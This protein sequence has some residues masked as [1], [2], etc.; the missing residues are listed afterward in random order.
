M[1]RLLLIATIAVSG[2]AAHAAEPPA[3]MPMP[4][5]MEAGAGALAI[6]QTF[7]VTAGL[8][9]A[10]LESALNRLVARLSRQTGMAIARGKPAASRRATLRV[11]CAARGPAYPTLGEDESYQ[12]EVTPEGAVLK[13]ATVDGAMH[14]LE[15]FAQL[16]EPGASGFQAPA[17]RI[18]DRPRFPWR[19][20]M[21]DVSRHWMPVEVVKRNLDAMA[22][23]KLN[24]FHWH[25]SDDQG[26]RVESKRY[27][28]LQQFGSG[29]HYYT[30]A[31]IR[32][33][34]AYARERGIRVVPEFDMPG[35][36]VSWFPGYPQLASGPGPY[37][38]GGDFGTFDPVMDPSREETYRFL[39]GFIGEMAALFP[40][41]FF[42]VGGDEVNGRQWS[43]SARVQAFARQHRFKDTRHI[44]LYFSQR[45]RR[46]LARHGKTMVGW[47]EILQPGLG[48][49]TVIDTW[50]GRASLAESVQQGYRG[51]LSW[52]YYLDH[53]K[54]ASDHYGVDPLAGDAA[55]LTPE[56]AHRILGGEACMWSELVSPETVDSRIW[57]RMAAIAERF[58]SAEDV[59]DVNSM[60]RRLEVVSRKLEWTGIEHRANYAPMLDR[61]SGNQPAPPVRV[62]ADACEALGLG[63]RQAH[64]NTTQTPL[65]RMVDAARP[66]SESVRAL[67]LAAAR[68]AANPA[69]AVAD[70]VTLRAQFTRWATNDRDFQPLAEANSLLEE[71]KPISRDLSY[72]GLLGL[73]LL[74]VVGAGQ[75]APSDWLATQDAELKRMLEP[76]ADLRLAAVRPVKILLDAAA[77]TAK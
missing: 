9:D 66:E 42:H 19:G 14:G 1:H 47:D 16:V 33:V 51:I 36:T 31:E 3:L 20:L 40:D 30:Q 72:V 61:L 56:Q 59:T 46:I 6:D 10:R 45:I 4:L 64:R 38:I 11:E 76:D 58:W 37:E 67:E 52:G 8:A 70:V 75:P 54:P 5:K 18:D 7:T 63:P 50:R 13:S 35:H 48:S 25:L 15:T 44:Q 77:G 74:D 71:L 27:S 24:V 22:A 12:L 39:D 62:L 29:G 34:V 73:R 28:R 26:F 68:V 49:G 23:V 57:P 41:P 32:A 43:R 17:V 60:Y 65:N 53:L 2:S 21:L 55:Q 69:A